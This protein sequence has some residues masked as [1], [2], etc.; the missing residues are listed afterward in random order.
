MDHYEDEQYAEVISEVRERFELMAD[1]EID[2]IRLKCER[3]K[4][5]WDNEF[6]V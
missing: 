2:L 4:E 1:N 6:D 5:D 3:L